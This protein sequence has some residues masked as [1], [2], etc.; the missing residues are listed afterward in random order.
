M[1]SKEEIETIAKLMRIEIDDHIV[2]MDRVEKMIEYFEILDKAGVEKDELALQEQ[3]I[4]NL[5]DDKHIPFNE[6]LIDNLK[7]YKSR[8]VKAP[9]MI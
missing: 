4:E 6:N 3:R 8:Y 1:V 2:H 7:N 9:K 5:R